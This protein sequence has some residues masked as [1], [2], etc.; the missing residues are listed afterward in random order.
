MKLPHFLRIQR[1]TDTAKRL[2]RSLDGVDIPLEG[3]GEV[4]KFLA[5]VETFLNMKKK[6]TPLW[7][8]LIFLPVILIATASAGHVL[9]LDKKSSEPLRDKALT[10]LL[11]A[12]TAGVGFYAGKLG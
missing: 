5:N 12:L 4:S 8:H 7:V 2:E 11:A 9:V 1:K 6:K 3:A 10:G